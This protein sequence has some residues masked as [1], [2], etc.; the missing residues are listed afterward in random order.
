MVNSDSAIVQTKKLRIVDADWLVVVKGVENAAVN[1]NFNWT[2]S[3]TK[4][5]QSKDHGFC[6]QANR[7]RKHTF[8]VGMED[9]GCAAVEAANPQT[10]S[11]ECSSL[12]C[13]TEEQ[14]FPV[15]HHFKKG[16]SQVSINEHLLKKDST[17][18]METNVRPG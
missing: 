8:S 9:T 10:D 12:T 14:F 3:G 13:G 4:T 18:Y 15:S 2:H 11:T 5:I 1:V 6:S 7:T 16:A 17:D